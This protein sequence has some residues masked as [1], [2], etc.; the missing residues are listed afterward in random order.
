PRDLGLGR[1]G[2]QARLDAAHEDTFSG[3]RAELPGSVATVEDWP[4]M[5]A[6]A[7]LVP[8]GTRTF[9]AD[10]PAPPDGPAREYLHVSLA[11][12][13]DQLVDL[14][15][16]S[17]E[18]LGDSGSGEV[19]QPGGVHDAAAQGHGAQGAQTPGAEYH[20]AEL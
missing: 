4:A 15:L 17:G 13:R 8:S 18:L 2:L 16:Q 3:M 14:L 1:P 6:A 19:Q 20:G 7:S 12:R 9:L 11:Q 5:L 10:R